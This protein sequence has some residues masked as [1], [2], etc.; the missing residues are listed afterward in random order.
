M[1]QSP[2][3]A[4]QLGVSI[5]I[6]MCTRSLTLSASH[7]HGDQFGNDGNDDDNDN[8]NDNDKTFFVA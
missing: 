7:R 8:E 2:H 6:G 4:W 1:K 3:W 5:A